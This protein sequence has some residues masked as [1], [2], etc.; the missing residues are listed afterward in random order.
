MAAAH[1]WPDGDVSV[2]TRRPPPRRRAT[3]RAPR[4]RRLR[5]RRRRGAPGR[6]GRRSPTVD[7][8]RAAPDRG[9]AAVA[10]SSSPAT[11]TTDPK[12]AAATST[13]SGGPPSGAGGGGCRRLRPGSLMLRRWSAITP[14]TIR[15]QRC[16]VAGSAAGRRGWRRAGQA[17]EADRAEVRLA[18]SRTG[19]TSK[20]RMNVLFAIL[21][22]R[23]VG[24]TKRP[25]EPIRPVYAFAGPYA[26]RMVTVP[27]ARRRHCAADGAGLVGVGLVCVLD[28][29]LLGSVEAQAQTGCART[30]TAVRTSPPRD[31]A[32]LV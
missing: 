12:L 5:S 22:R 15:E 14:P 4:A 25:S 32:G 6:P 7:R 11:V 27:T 10:M 19:G 18:R 17:V 24:R 20:L 1:P 26:R 30:A 13:S 28:A 9:R 2:H 8:A 31:A 29:D 3:G 16:S 23:W 21:R